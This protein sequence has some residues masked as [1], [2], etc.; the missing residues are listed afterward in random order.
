MI[1][2]DVTD[3]G[4]REGLDKEKA[5]RQRR[6][7]VMVGRR[8]VNWRL[9]KYDVEQ[10]RDLLD[11]HHGAYQRLAQAYTRGEITRMDPKMIEQMLVAYLEQIAPRA[12]SS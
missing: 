4:Q 5:R 2:V 9:R 3:E 11:R 8:H 12:R 6:Q 1:I 7:K 10:A